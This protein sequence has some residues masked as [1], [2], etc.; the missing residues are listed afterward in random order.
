MQF[1]TNIISVFKYEVSEIGK[2]R[3]Y[4]TT[5][6]ILPLATLLFF[7]V[8]FGRGSI[9]NLPI[10]VVDN[11]HSS[12][13]RQLIAMVNATRGIEVT[14][15][16][17][18]TIEAEKLLRRGDAYGMIFIPEG[19]EQNIYSSNRTDIECYISG[20]NLSASGVIESELQNCVRTLS[21]GVELSKLKVQGVNSHN[22]MQE[23]MPINF[24]THIISNPY[25]NYGYYLAPIFMF[26]AIAIF[27]TLL[28]T[29]SVG[30]ELYYSTAPK[31]MGIASND[32]IA[33]IIGKLLPTTIAMILFSQLSYFIIFIIMGMEC[34]GNYLFL[35]IGST[36]LILAYQSVALFITTI[37]SNMRLAL[38]LG[39]GYSVMAF[40]FSGI[41][42]P[43][44]AMFAAIRP[45]TNIFPLTWF[46][47]IFI[48]QA[49]R[50]TPITLS[51][52]PL[53]SLLLFL[54]L[55]LFI[56]KRLQK[57]TSEPQYWSKD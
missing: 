32:T 17:T 7:G 35:S 50:G 18:S 31:W 15:S 24:L 1:I 51:L 41:T 33:A 55:P 46:T 27:T 10:V 40:T 21:A 45:L 2:N 29:Y 4:L 34:A 43:A 26:M 48:D 42:I 53:F 23:I 16:S 56:I 49:M 6:L 37:T 38:S 39:G 5:L 8:M 22:A 12:T 54:F 52:N 14:F 25:V 11:D 19:L 57:I 44:M 9:A 30:R 36:I 28:T 13:S 20:T 3:V 47:E